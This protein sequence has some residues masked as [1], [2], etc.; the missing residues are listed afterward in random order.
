[1]SRKKQSGRLLSMLA[2]ARNH[3]IAKG[4]ERSKL[5]IGQS[6]LFSHTYQK[7]T[8]VAAQSWVTKGKFLPRLDIKGRGRF[9]MKHH[10]SA[11]MHVLLA[12]GKTEQERRRMHEREKYRK[13]IRGQAEPLGSAGV[14]KTRPLINTPVAGWRW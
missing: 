14:G 13:R 8:A 1:M 12:E 4:M 6:S 3:A 2:L 7:L 9:G 10:P 11:K 5:V